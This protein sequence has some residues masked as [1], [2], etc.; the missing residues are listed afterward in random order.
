MMQNDTLIEGVGSALNGAVMAADGACAPHEQQLLDVRLCALALGA[1]VVAWA[2]DAACTTWLRLTHASNKTG[3]TGNS[4]HRPVKARRSEW[5]LDAIAAAE[6]ANLRHRAW[7]AY[8]SAGKGK[9]FYQVQQADALLRHPS[10]ERCE[11]SVR[12]LHREVCEHLE[13]A[14]RRI[15]DAPTTADELDNDAADVVPVDVAALRRDC[16]LQLAPNLKPSRVVPRRSYVR[17][18]D[19]IAARRPLKSSARFNRTTQTDSTDYWLCKYAFVHRQEFEALVGETEAET[20]GS[21]ALGGQGSLEGAPSSPLQR[22]GDDLS[23]LRRSLDTFNTTRSQL[24]QP[25]PPNEDVLVGCSA[26]EGPDSTRMPAQDTLVSIGVSPT[27][28]KSALAPAM[29]PKWSPPVSPLERPDGL[30]AAKSP[31]EAASQEAQPSVLF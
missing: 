21:T 17:G 8:Q 26:D 15:A 12:R 11:A 14:D 20:P 6:D 7:L 10:Q 28:V 19:D 29:L 23:E 9:V 31:D 25:P 24:Y 16:A 2:L 30:P 13:H 22:L 3:Y 1:V 27:P 4:F 18:I 5:S